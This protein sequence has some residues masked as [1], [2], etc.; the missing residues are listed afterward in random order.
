[1]EI[2]GNNTPEYWLD[3][4]YSFIITGVKNNKAELVEVGWYG[5]I[6]YW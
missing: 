2:L 5:A 1:M 3:N 4:I 6:P